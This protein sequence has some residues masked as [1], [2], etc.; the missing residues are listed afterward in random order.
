M[1]T[2][3]ASIYDWVDE[4]LGLSELAVFARKK[5]VPVHAQAFWYVGIWF[6]I[7][8]GKPAESGGAEVTRS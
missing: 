1:T 5:T 2:K 6:A 4:R 3:T 7:G 8:A